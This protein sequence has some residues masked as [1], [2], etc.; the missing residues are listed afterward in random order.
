[1]CVDAG[2][3]L[4]EWM[5]MCCPLDYVLTSGVRDW[6]L[7]DSWLRPR[8]SARPRQGGGAAPFALRICYAA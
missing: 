2:R 6:R 5:L 1:M 4:H 3:R 7:E 8:E